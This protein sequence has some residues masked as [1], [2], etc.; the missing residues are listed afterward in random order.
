MRSNPPERFD[1]SRTRSNNLPTAIAYCATC[2]KWEPV[3]DKL[4]GYR[5]D[6]PSWRLDSIHVAAVIGTSWKHAKW[7]KYIVKLESYQRL[8]GRLPAFGILI[9]ATVIGLGAGL[10]RC[11]FFSMAIG[12][13]LI[14][15]TML[16][17]SANVMSSQRPRFAPRSIFFATLGLVQLVLGFGFLYFGSRFKFLVSGNKAQLSLVQSVYF[18]IVTIVTLGYGDITPPS[19]ESVVLLVVAFQILCAVYYLSVFIATVVSWVRGIERPLALKELLD[20]SD[21]LDKI[22]HGK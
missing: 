3:N 18:S 4:T 12:F 14:L 22:D 19:N 20:C 15:D 1:P 16:F 11:Y 9:V 8:R 7:V 13:I 21:R 17:T 6:C 2:N 5:F 10:L